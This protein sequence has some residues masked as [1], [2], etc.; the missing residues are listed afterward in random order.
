MTDTMIENRYEVS[1]EDSQVRGFYKRTWNTIADIDEKL[2]AGSEAAGKRKVTNELVEQA[3]GEWGPVAKNIIEE[4]RKLTDEERVGVLYGLNRE[5]TSAFKEE[6]EK[7]VTARVEALPKTEDTLTD[8]QKK[9]LAAERSEL[10][11]QIKLIVNMAGTFG[12]FEEGNEWPLPKRRGAVGKRGKRALSF[13]DWSIDGV[14]VPDD[15]NSVK[16]VAEMLGF[17][18]QAEFTKA[19]KECMVGDKKLDTTNPPERFSVEING[20]TVTAVKGATEE[21]PTA[22]ATEPTVD[23]ADDDEDED[24]DEDDE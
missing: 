19:L 11:N 24:E 18:K 7:L 2:D 3:K 1:E 20:K 8:E 6:A 23:E 9:A 15:Q 14:D 4:M 22:I 10:A 13:Y 21:D 12:E 17:E 5:L 16:G